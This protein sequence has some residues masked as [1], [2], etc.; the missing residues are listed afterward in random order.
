MKVKVEFTLVN[1]HAVETFSWSA[2]G[3]V[4]NYAHLVRSMNEEI[5]WMQDKALRMKESGQRIGLV[6]ATNIIKFSA[7]VY[8][9][10]WEDVGLDEVSAKLKNIR[11]CTRAKDGWKAGDHALHVEVVV[12]AAMRALK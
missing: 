5:N 9:D 10:S 6:S 11:L 12:E 7:S 1:N 2:M 4:N 3:D 8:K